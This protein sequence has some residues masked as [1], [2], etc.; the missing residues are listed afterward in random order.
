[1]IPC[2]EPSNQQEAYDMKHKAFDFSE[3]HRVPVMLRVT[4]RLAHSRAG[5]T[6]KEV[7]SQTKFHYTQILNNLF[8]S[9][10]THAYFIKKH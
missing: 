7:R 4:T 10:V 2:F 1:M 6:R 3:K 9:P 8:Y 5:V